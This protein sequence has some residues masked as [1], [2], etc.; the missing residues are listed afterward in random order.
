[1]SLALSFLQGVVIVAPST[2]SAVLSWRREWIN[3]RLASGVTEA[4]RLLH[5]LTNAAL[6]M[7]LE[8]TLGAFSQAA[9][10]LLLIAIYV[11]TREPADA[12]SS[13][14][15]RETAALATMIV[16]LAIIISVGQQIYGAVIFRPSDDLLSTTTLSQYVLRNAISTI[17]R[18]CEL[19]VAY[20]IFRSQTDSSTNLDASQETLSPA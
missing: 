16:G 2:Y 9:L 3:F 19:V 13:H 7:Q 10:L 8:L 20:V 15:L 4:E 17:P 18:V 5:W 1:L 14:V 12:H 6:T 11:H